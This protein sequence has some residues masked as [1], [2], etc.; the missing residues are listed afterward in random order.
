MFLTY[1]D[2][3]P[4]ALF[5]TGIFHYFKLML[6]VFALY[7]VLLV[8]AVIMGPRVRA[9]AALVAVVFGLFMWRVDLTHASA[10]PPITDPSRMA[11][12]DGL[13][14]MNDAV[15]AEGHGNLTALYQATNRITSTAGVFN[16]FYDYKI[17]AASGTIMILPLRPMPDAPGTLMLPPDVAMDV[18]TTPMLARQTFVWGLPCWWLPASRAAC[19]TDSKSVLA[20]FFRKEPLP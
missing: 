4:P 5:R 12:P 20:L 14:R 16:S 8:R 3:H 2:L 18:G 1:R 19:G 6:P 15:L 9:G 13:S 7:A 10:L 17:Y 11:L